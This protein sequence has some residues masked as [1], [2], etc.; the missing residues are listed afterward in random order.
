MRSKK[1]SYLLDICGWPYVGI[2]GVGRVFLFLGDKY[3]FVALAVSVLA[4]IIELM[5]PILA[6][7][8]KY[9][10]PWH[11]HHIAERYALLLIIILGEG[12][13]GTSKAIIALLGA[14]YS[15]FSVALPI[16]LGTA[17]IIFALWW[18]YFQIP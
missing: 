17:V 4:I 7:G 8:R 3:G 9:S 11:P 15:G 1:S 14:D 18:S 12:L 5:T 6:E 2:T 10:T 13:W 16:G